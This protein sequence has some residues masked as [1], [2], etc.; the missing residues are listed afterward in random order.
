MDRNLT[1]RT[2][3]QRRNNNIAAKHRRAMQF[4]ES[5]E[6][7]KLKAVAKQEQRTAQEQL[8]EFLAGL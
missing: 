4:A 2:F 6:E 7:H 1:Q 8:Q 3:K 5:I